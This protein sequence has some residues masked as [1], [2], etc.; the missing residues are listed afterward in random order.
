MNEEKH[1]R[2][3][4]QRVQRQWSKSVTGELK[5]WEFSVAEVEW[6]WETIVEDENRKVME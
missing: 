1:F 2:Q 3:R 6:V 5:N 4:E